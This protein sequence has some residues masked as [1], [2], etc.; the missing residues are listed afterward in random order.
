[1]A[2]HSAG[3][4]GAAVAAAFVALA[5]RR[6][7]AVAVAATLVALV[8]ANG[9][10]PGLKDVFLTARWGAL[11]AL[12]AASLVFFAE[13]R[14]ADRWQLGVLA[15]LPA[16]AVVSAIWSVDPRL[17]IGRT[18]A[19]TSML[20]VAVGAG[21]RARS[22][23]GQEFVDGLALA[24]A[25]VVA[26]TI[27]V[28]VV[29]STGVANGQLRG[30][31]ENPNGLGLFLGMTAPAVMASLDARGRLWA[32]PPAL[33]VL[34]SIAVL[35]HSRSGL[36]ALL[37][38]T[39][40]YDAARRRWRWLAIEGAVV[41]VAVGVGLAVGKPLLSNPSSAPTTGVVSAPAPNDVGGAIGAP[42]TALDRL[43]GA[44]IEAWRA[45]TSLIGSR[46]V[47][48]YGFGTGDRI[49]ARYPDRAHFVYFQGANP[50]NGYLQFA[51]ELG[52]LGTLLFVLPLGWAFARAVAAV[53]GTVTDAP[54][55][56]TVATLA[57]GLAAGVVESIFTSPGA[58]WDP[59]V[60]A[61]A[62]MVVLGGVGVAERSRAQLDSRLVALFVAAVAL[63][64]G[65]AAY[66]VRYATRPKPPLTTAE[67]RFLARHAIRAACVTCGQ[68]RVERVDRSYWFGRGR[69]RSAANP[70]C[71][72]VD[73]RKRSESFAVGTGCASPPLVL[74]HALTVGV[75]DSSPPYFRPPATD[76]TG[77]EP[78]LMRELAHRLHVSLIRWAE[79]RRSAPAAVDV[80]VH[81]TRSHLNGRGVFMPYVALRDALLARPAT[82]AAKATTTATLATFRVGVTSAQ[83][84]AFA[85]RIRIARRLTVF[86]SVEAGVA[87]LRRG[88]VDALLAEPNAAKQAADASSGRVVL[89][90]LLP[91]RLYYGIELGRAKSSALLARR[92]EEMLD[93]GTVARLRAQVIG[94]YP[95]AP[96]LR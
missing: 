55:A 87:A 7:Y 59:I 20:V 67:A 42:G 13:I 2:E 41:L 83:E 43:T 9:S 66:A 51:L 45:T 92:F 84:R 31:F 58:P 37:I 90:A 65:G 16:F 52:V 10:V 53:R 88:D 23:G 70:R 19:F 22:K 25:I 5:A 3:L 18:V 29:G 56:A 94:S 80:V 34:G 62:G 36:G 63:G 1:V 77:L 95:A 26:A 75:R 96:V 24:A 71:F 91:P 49:F 61:T 35:S 93:D 46:P 8:F 89:V 50:N 85:I 6:S 30:I 72:L 32:M 40:V 28:A 12:A 17:T 60:W 73:V 21:L 69:E 11:A 47:V 27:A 54:G 44:R 39:V 4:V 76:P 33:I 86:P 78:V 82:P 48:G 79:A 64:V 15:A 81:A 38:G 57:A 68:V 74:P 14:R